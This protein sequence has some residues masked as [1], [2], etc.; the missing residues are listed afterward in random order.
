MFL[1]NTQTNFG[2]NLKMH[3][4]IILIGYI[5]D[6]KCGLV[7]LAFEQYTYH[8]IN[9]LKESQSPGQKIL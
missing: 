8:H 3:V 9:N 6:L 7:A 4:I 2:R 5:K 1:E